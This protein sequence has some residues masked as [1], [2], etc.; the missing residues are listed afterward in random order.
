[1]LERKGIVLPR[2][3]PLDVCGL[4]M[5]YLVGHLYGWKKPLT[6]LAALVGLLP[7]VVKLARGPERPQ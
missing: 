4:R 3:L 2:N 5:G 7:L 6:A 1:M